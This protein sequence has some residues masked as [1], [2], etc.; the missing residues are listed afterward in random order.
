[1]AEAQWLREGGAPEEERGR[2]APHRL[3]GVDL[4]PSAGREGGCM[5][6]GAEMVWVGHLR[7]AK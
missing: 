7:I 1:M 2:Q 6:K 5:D 4:M 3:G